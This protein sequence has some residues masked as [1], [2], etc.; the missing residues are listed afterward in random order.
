[1]KTGTNGDNPRKKQQGEIRNIAKRETKQQERREPETMMSK[2]ETHRKLG[3]KVIR[4]MHTEK[5]T[6]K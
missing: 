6:N 1:M 3:I 2:K 5:A 4:R